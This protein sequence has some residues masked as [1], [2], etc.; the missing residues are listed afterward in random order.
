MA[1]AIGPFQA[2]TT[3]LWLWNMGPRTEIDTASCCQ[4]TEV[5]KSLT[6]AFAWHLLLRDLPFLFLPLGSG[7]EEQALGPGGQSSARRQHVW[8]LKG[9]PNGA[10]WY[11]WGLHSLTFCC[12][13]GSLRD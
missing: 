13:A 11:A 4:G 3:Q 1:P 9:P 12:C 2:E 7:S 5:P 8:N 6:L 10:G